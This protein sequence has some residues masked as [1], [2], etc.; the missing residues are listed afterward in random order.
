MVS[1]ETSALVAGAIRAPAAAAPTVTVRVLRGVMVGGLRIEPG[2]EI[3]VERWLAAELV[4][5]GKAERIA[6]PA[7]PE[8]KPAAKPAERKTRAEQ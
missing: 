2:A 1:A 3:P 7:A 4:T 6:A 8:P 5:A